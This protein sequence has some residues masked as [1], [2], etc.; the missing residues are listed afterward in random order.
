MKVVI[1][2]GVA[3]GTKTAAKL[4]RENPN[5]EVIIYTKSKD[6]SYAGCGLPYYVGGAVESDEELVVNT[7]EKFTALTGVS[8][9]TE[10]EVTALNS[11]NKTITVNGEN[12]SYDKLVLAVGAEPVIPDVKGVN[13]DGVF[14]V[15]EPADAVKI[16]N[17]S[18]TA[19]KAVVA[20][21]GF[22]G[23]EMA[24]N[25][26][27][28]GIS[29]TL[30]D[31][32]SQLMPDVFDSEMADLIRRKLQEK[33][34]RVVLG[35][36]LNAVIGDG[37]VSAVQTT[38][39][40]IPADMVILS[41]GI[42]PATK[43]LADSG[44]EMQKGCI[45]TD[46][47][48]KTNI[49]DIYAVGDCAMVKNRITGKKQWSAMG[50]TANITGRALA[51][52]LSG[53]P[54]AYKGVLGTAIIKLAK[55]LNA[56]VTGLTEKQAVDAGFD[57]IT[58][59]TASDSK[60]HY[61]PDSDTFITKL[62]ADRSTHRLLGAQIIGAGAV[63]KMADIAVVGITAELRIDDFVTMDF[64]YAP[65]FSTAIHPFAVACSVLL[66]K[67]NGKIET[68]TPAEYAKTHAKGYTIIDAHPAP[69][70]SGADWLDISKA[71]K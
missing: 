3:A 66:N 56:A 43:F 49:E 19:K 64:A 45:I 41:V 31:M 28:K 38:S 42:R 34:L 70:I 40:E 9:Y 58:V 26:M 52:T 11:G 23:L 46:E 67:I 44:L 16:K 33:G 20:G 15:R 7:P 71:D 6:I 69:T 59:V 27:E 17:Y 14:T 36:T 50:S 51:L 2:G 1:I 57:A 32:A 13:L 4:K 30:I 10:K 8:V 68:I 55:D 24:E 62:V 12:V 53:E 39:G 47:Y 60:A 22:I 25:L 21:G 35:T 5:D 54:T 63:D 61:Y 48:A 37:K 29:V 18:V 65:P